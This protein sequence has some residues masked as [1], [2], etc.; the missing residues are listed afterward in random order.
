MNK[1]NMDKIEKS[2]LDGSYEKVR[3]SK[4]ATGLEADAIAIAMTGDN[5]LQNAINRDK[6]LKFNEQVDEYTEKLSAE[7]ENVME[8][9]NS[10]ADNLEGLEIMPLYRDVIV[11]P[12]D[13]NPYQKIQ[14]TKSGIITD[15][16]GMTPTYK[17]NE[18][19]ETEEAEAFILVGKVIEAGPECKYVRSGDDVFFVKPSSVAVPFFKQGLVSI[20]EINLKAVINEGLRTRFLKSTNGKLKPFEK[21]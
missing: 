20:S 5:D 6:K 9:T 21:Y 7:I 4:A 1:C 15:L 17:S 14:V 10:I 19:G 18:T 12:Y 13:G 3:L 8:R 16:G 11:K 2:M